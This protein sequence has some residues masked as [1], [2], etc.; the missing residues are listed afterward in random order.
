MK[1]SILNII[2][3]YVDSDIKRVLK[4]INKHFN[5][6]IIVDVTYGRANAAFLLTYLKTNRVFNI[7]IAIIPNKAML[8]ECIYISVV[9]Y[10]TDFKRLV[11]ALNQPNK[12]TEIIGMFTYL[13]TT[14]LNILK[15]SS[16]IDKS[17]QKYLSYVL[18]NMNFLNDHV[19]EDSIYKEWLNYLTD[20]ND[21]SFKI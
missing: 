11:F 17:K 15:L 9:S 10:N 19:N 6:T 20:N 16:F 8:K 13:N 3:K 2:I 1:N 5:K 21:N 4:Q 14:D 18:N 12:K 7:T